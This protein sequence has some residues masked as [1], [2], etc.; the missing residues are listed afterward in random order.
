[1]QGYYKNPEA[2]RSVLS[3]DGWLRT[4]DLGFVD[5]EGYVYVTGASRT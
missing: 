3:Q 2:T 1:M 5:A 4:G